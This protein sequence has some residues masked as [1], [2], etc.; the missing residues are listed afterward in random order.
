MLIER[1]TLIC[2]IKVMN[3]KLAREYFVAENEVKWQRI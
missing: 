3:N 1:A 2:K